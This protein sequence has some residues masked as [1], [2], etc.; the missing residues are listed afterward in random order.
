MIIETTM[1]T[2]ERWIYVVGYKPPNVK[3]SVFIDT[4]CLMCD[5]ILNESNNVMILG[6]YNCDFM[7]DNALKDLCISYDIHN[8][9]S[10]PTCHKSSMG[11]LI[12]VCLVSKPLRFKT[13]FNFDCWLSDFHNFICIT[14]KLSFPKRPPRVIQYRSYKNFVDELFISDLFIL[15]HTMMYCDYD[16]NMCIDFFVT[17]LNFI[18]DKHAPLKYK[19]V[20]QNNVPYM[21]SELRKLNYQRNIV[22]ECKE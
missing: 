8:L 7:S 14:T 12:D 1:N 15:S 19:K 6:D 11:T 16:I 21:N 20:R 10:A 18:I 17:H 22:K 13:T 4:F 5:L 9:V 3:S 2:K